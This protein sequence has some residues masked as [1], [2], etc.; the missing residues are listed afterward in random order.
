MNR[1]EFCTSSFVLVAALGGTKTE[2]FDNELVIRPIEYAGALRNPLKGLRS[3]DVQT[4]ARYPF[5]S[6]A[7]AYI[8]WNDIESDANDRV[9][10][11]TDYCDRQWKDLH[12]S[13]TKVVPRVYLE[14]PNR[15]RYWP[16][17]ITNGDYSSAEFKRRL[18]RMIEK[19]G[20]AWNSD[21]RVAYGNWSDWVVGRAA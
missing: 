9:D 17:D 14:W 18:V 19:L 12:S 11:I 13:N 3:G 10:R 1:R 15:G 16:S 4:A 5:A 8:R 6:L 21:P 20:Q 2:S 7:K